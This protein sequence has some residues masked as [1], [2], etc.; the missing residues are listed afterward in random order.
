MGVAICKKKCR[1]AACI[2]IF[3]LTCTT[4]SCAGAACAAGVG[5]FV[6]TDGRRGLL[7]E[8]DQGGGLDRGGG[9]AG[10]SDAVHDR[11]SLD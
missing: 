10:Y 2:H 4:G 1:L 11:V 8:V 9:G 6:G 7:P 3:G 5:S